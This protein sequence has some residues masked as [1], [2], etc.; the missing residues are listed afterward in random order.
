[1]AVSIHYV[2][3]GLFWVNGVGNVVL[4]ND[5]A[6]KLDDIKNA[7][8]QEHRVIP[9]L[10]GNAATPSS[11]DYPSIEDY[12]ALEAAADHAFSYMDQTQIITQMIT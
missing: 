4:K 11:A 10:T 7:V 9:N 6:T 5:P 2:N 12:L 3:V 1:M 8:A